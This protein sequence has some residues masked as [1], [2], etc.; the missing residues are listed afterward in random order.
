MNVP[1][2][3]K[4]Y[5][6][7]GYRASASSAVLP[8]IKIAIASAVI[9]SLTVMGSATQAGVGSVPESQ[10]VQQILTVQ[11]QDVLARTTLAVPVLDVPTLARWHD[12]TPAPAGPRMYEN[13]AAKSHEI[14]PE[15]RIGERTFHVQEATKVVSMPKR[16][17]QA[18]WQC[19][20][21]ALY[22]EA[23]SESVQGQR[24]VAEVILNRVDSRKFPNTV[25]DVVH[26]GAHRKHACQF[27][28]NCDGLPEHIAE[29][30]AYARA[31][32]IALDMVGEG[33]RDLT[34]GATHYHT[35]AVSPGWSR[36]LSKTTK[37]GTHIFYRDN[38]V[39]SQR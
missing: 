16:R 24:A 10:I 13:H 17:G 30:K 36:R 1:M 5:Q 29:P 18:Q 23:R 26:Q 37:I 21:E 3:I 7:R 34:S 2:D 25:C 19:L 22:F 33:A 15:S 4:T 32:A 14:A 11:G 9:G 38:T 31:K 20:A 39:I 35:S 12:I 8:R 27:S 28:Y 6:A